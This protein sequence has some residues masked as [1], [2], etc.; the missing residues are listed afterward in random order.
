M[1]NGHLSTEWRSKQDHYVRR[2]KIKTRTNTG[3]GW[4]L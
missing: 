1:F 3:V 4:S 2:R